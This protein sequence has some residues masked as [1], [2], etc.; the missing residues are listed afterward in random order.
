MISRYRTQN[1]LVIYVLRYSLHL[2][3]VDG[4]FVQ[5]DPGEKPSDHPA[6]CE[7]RTTVT[8]THISSGGSSDSPEIWPQRGSVVGGG[9]AASNK[10]QYIL[11]SSAGC[12]LQAG[13]LR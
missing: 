8:G 5:D 4:I 12:Y 1:R 3:V 11:Q 9:E 2:E 7:S 13:F 6:V 10:P